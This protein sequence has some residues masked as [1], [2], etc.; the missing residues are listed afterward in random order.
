MYEDTFVRR[1][2]CTSKYFA[3]RFIFAREL[4]KQKKNIYKI[5]DKLLKNINKK[6]VIDRG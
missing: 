1:Q 2:F 4:K 5:K 6:N 3:Q